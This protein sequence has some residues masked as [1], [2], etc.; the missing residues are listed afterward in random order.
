MR[1]V[2]LNTQQKIKMATIA[3]ELVSGIRRL[4]GKSDQVVI[5]RNGITWELDLQEGI[6]FSIFLLGGFELATLRLYKS[7]LKAGDIVLDI[8][9][10]IGA[11]TLPFAKL[12]GKNGR[13][14]A[15]EPTH[16]AFEKLGKNVR[17]NPAISPSIELVHAMLISENRDAIA[18]EIYSSWPLHREEGL[19]ERHRGKL[20]STSDAAAFTLDEFMDQKRIACV[21]F[22]KLDVDGNEASVLAGA[23]DT[24][25]RFRPR[26]L[27]EWAPYLFDGKSAV[28]ELVL[29]N[30]INLG[31]FPKEPSRRRLLPKT[32]E[33][34]NSLVPKYGSMNVLFE[35]SNVDGGK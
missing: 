2:N 27:M 13:V 30:F 19:H 21:N 24:L 10:N 12:V 9:A 18:P 8:G 14:Y 1:V 22:I 31:Y 32:V 17:A 35:T 26:V 34:L 25:R 16:Y 11:H 3:Y 23:V 7:I 20:M 5:R 6:D 33:A 28:M 29:S 4:L 15:F